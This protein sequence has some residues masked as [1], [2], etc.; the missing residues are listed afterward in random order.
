MKILSGTCLGGSS[1]SYHLQHSKEFPLGRQPS[2]TSTVN[3]QKHQ[4]A[5]FVCYTHSFKQCLVSFHFHLVL[6][7]I[8]WFV[9]LRLTLCQIVGFSRII[10]HVVKLKVFLQRPE[11]NPEKYEKFSRPEKEKNMKTYSAACTLSTG[12]PQISF[13]LSFLMLNWVDFYQN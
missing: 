8:C 1:V 11:K 12:W 9:H 6:L 3:H 2:E 13:Q 10:D 4:M 5:L 7:S